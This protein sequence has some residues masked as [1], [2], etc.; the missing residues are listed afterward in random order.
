MDG[1]GAVAVILPIQV[2]IPVRFSL[3]R[4]RATMLRVVHYCMLIIVGV[5]IGS[6]VC[7]ISGL[8]GGAVPCRQ[9][10]CKCVPDCA[11]LPGML[12]CA[13]CAIFSQSSGVLKQ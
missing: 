13:A 4:R 11:L 6:G 2:Y 1:C 7:S 12:Y 5:S 8:S 9:F 10:L 3:G